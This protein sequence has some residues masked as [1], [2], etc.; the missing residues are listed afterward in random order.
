MSS[1]YH[2]PVL[3]DEVIQFL[4]TKHDGVYV[5]GTLGGGGHAENILEKIYP[6]RN[7]R[8]H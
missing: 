3:R 2:L 8:R 6:A 1:P 4:I 5:D 7:A